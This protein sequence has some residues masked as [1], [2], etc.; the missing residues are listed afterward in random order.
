MAYP[1]SWR[2]PDSRVIHE[3]GRLIGHLLLD[4]G[5]AVAFLCKTGWRIG[6]VRKLKSAVNFAEGVVRIEADA[7]KNDE[8]RTFPFAAHPELRGLIEA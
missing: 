2:C 8:A 6:E 7:T 4:L 1:Q 5:P 3:F